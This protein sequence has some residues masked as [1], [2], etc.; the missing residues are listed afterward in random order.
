MH[1][2]INIA[3]ELFMLK[4]YSCLKLSFVQHLTSL[5]LFEQLNFRKGTVKYQ[6]YFSVAAHI[7]GKVI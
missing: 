4:C 6:R 1:N 2:F 5:E 3:V 7:L